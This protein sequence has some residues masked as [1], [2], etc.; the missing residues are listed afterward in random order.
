MVKRLSYK[1]FAENAPK[2]WAENTTGDAYKGGLSR[3]APP[4]KSVKEGRVKAYEENT[5]EKEAKHWFK[6]YINAMFE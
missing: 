4:G 5:T 3:I 6:Q 1:D 2:L